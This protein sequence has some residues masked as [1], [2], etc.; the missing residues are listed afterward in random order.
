MADRIVEAYTGEYAAGKSENAL[1]R[2]LELARRGRLVTLVDLDIVEPFYTLRPI[3]D[4]LAAHGLT[5]LAWKTGETMGLGEAGTVIKP[6]A[7]WA[8]RR[9]G[10]VILDIGYG[11][12][13]SRTLNLVE[14]AGSDPD[15]KV[16]AVINISRPMT[17]SVA[18]IVQ[19]VRDLGRVAGLIN[20]T[21]LGDETTG[22]VVQEGARVVTEAARILGLP[23][24]ATAA[25]AEIAEKI[26]QA[27][28]MDNPVRPLTRFM[29][30]AM[31]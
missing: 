26:G 28:C 2:A 17:A 1:N 6:A 11:V 12:G 7:R 25:A 13:G 9:D 29:Q 5:V 31:W 20:N 14:G 19:H 23:V 18:D 15:L 16:L 22:E 24:V 4:E 21:H 3:Q 10:D 8:L 27:D 30:K